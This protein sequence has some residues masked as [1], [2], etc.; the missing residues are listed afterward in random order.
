MKNKK[1]KSPLVPRILLRFV[2]R[3]E[4][5]YEFSDDV[6][7]SYLQMRDSGPNGRPRPGIGSG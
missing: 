4:D 5:F 2:L 7:E 3:G 6:E 1:E